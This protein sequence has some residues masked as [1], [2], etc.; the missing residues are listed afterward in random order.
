MLRCKHCAV[1]VGGGGPLNG[2][3]FPEHNEISMKTLAKGQIWFGK[4]VFF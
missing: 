4:G 2:L 1:V 3:Q